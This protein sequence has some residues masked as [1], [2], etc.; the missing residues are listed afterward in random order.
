[1]GHT[2]QLR[3]SYSKL[4]LCASQFISAAWSEKEGVG[5]RTSLIVRDQSLSFIPATKSQC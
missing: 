1:M 2:N 5:D 3:K 4:N